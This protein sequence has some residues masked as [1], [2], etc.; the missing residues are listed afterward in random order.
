MLSGTASALLMTGAYVTGDLYARRPERQRVQSVAVALAGASAAAAVVFAVIV[1]D[2]LVIA[3]TLAFVT[4][5]IRT[6]NRSLLEVDA[7]RSPGSSVKDNE[8]SAGSATREATKPDD[9]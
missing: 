9:P 4:L 5:A 8:T 2:I 6:L 1:D 3:G 7:G